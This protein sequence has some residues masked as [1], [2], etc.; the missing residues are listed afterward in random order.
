MSYVYQ[1][2]IIQGGMG[3]GVSNWKLANAVSRLGQ[4]GVISGT[5]ID[6]VIVR[7]L[8]MGDQDGSVRRALANFP[9]PAI[10]ENIIER[11]FI[12]GGK[13]ENAPFKTTPVFSLKT[14]PHLFDL[15]VASSF[16]ETFLAKEGHTNPVGINL[17]TKIK[18]PNIPVLFGAL[19]AGVDYVLMGAGIPLK[20]PSILNDLVQG[21]ET[22]QE[23]D[24]AGEKSTWWQA[25]DPK[26]YF[27]MHYP[28][29]KRPQFF[30]IISST[31][32]ALTFA[33]KANGKVDGFVIESPKAGG[34][35]A[36][37][38]NK[39]AVTASG[40][41][42]Y[43]DRDTPDLEKISKLNI[44]YWLAGGFADKAHIAQ[45]KQ[46]G[47]KGV[48]IGTAFAFCNESGITQDLKRKIIAKVQQGDI[49]VR[50]DPHLSPTGFPFKIVQLEGTLSD[51]NVLQQRPQRCD[52]GY[53]REIHMDS[54]GKTTY[55]CPA[56]NQQNYVRKGGAA[57]NQVGKKC[58]CNS[59]CAAVGLGQSRQSNYSEPALVTAGDSLKEI[60]TFL[61]P[62]K[63]SY[64]AA[65]VIREL[66]D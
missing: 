61:K 46:L 8:Q 16:A 48:Q 53:L 51:D 52:L 10:A 40:E 55:R 23:I 43:T 60:K 54:H 2:T 36:P 20:F 65:T 22:G 62:G 50:T 45:A 37:P 66:L 31:V 34:H 58:L 33:K 15:A 42:I 28:K 38:R 7:R 26:K 12:P 35:N 57:A 5:A 1:P 44:P 64:S 4:L 47:A 21:K 30:P 6:T 63:D 39:D 59:L 17:L 25:F 13:A 19:L 27:P 14:P 49:D 29:L 3:V 41:P 11:Y 32:L 56:E 9:L 24:I 18:L